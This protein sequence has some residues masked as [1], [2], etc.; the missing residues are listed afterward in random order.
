[1]AEE[2]YNLAREK[3]KMKEVKFN[4]KSN[5]NLETIRRQRL[6]RRVDYSQI[7]SREKN[8]CRSSPEEKQRQRRG[9]TR[10]NGGRSR[11]ENASEWWSEPSGGRVGVEVVVE[12]R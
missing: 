10:R 6:H 9:R 5:S 1:M 3:T 11:A 4:Y 12:V 8:T 7:L 2:I